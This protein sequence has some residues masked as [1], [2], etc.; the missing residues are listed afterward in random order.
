[1]Y[2]KQETYHRS[3]ILSFEQLWNS[4]KTKNMCINKENKCINNKNLT[5]TKGLHGN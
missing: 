1:M 3:E 2:S 5:I 4:T